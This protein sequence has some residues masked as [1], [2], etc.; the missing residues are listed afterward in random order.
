MTSTAPAAVTSSSR[1]PM[2]IRALIVGLIGIAIPFL[3]PVA[4]YLGVTCVREID[5]QPG[6][7][8][9]RGLASAG[10]ALGIVGT[11]ELVLPVVM[12]LLLTARPA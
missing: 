8:S 11:I 5:A 10:L 9:G 7:W 12:L 4:L 6:R 2:S 1:H 3:G